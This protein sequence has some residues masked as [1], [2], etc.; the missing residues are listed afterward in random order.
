MKYN[1]DGDPLNTFSK[2][3]EVITAALGAT[4][5]DMISLKKMY[6][7]RVRILEQRRQQASRRAS[8]TSSGRPTLHPSA[9][10]KRNLMFRAHLDP[11]KSDSSTV[12]STPS[13]IDSDA[14][15]QAVACQAVANLGYPGL[16]TTWGDE[17]VR[18]AEATLAHLKRIET[19]AK[20]TGRSR[21]W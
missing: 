1:T 6:Y 20:G 13:A 18:K 9:D 8:M 16:S 14:V 4:F 2:H 15:D 11:Q 7:R 21:P 12:G 3:V 19:N 17:M 10:K 5:V